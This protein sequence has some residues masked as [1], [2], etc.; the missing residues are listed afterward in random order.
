MCKEETY[1]LWVIT[2]LSIIAFRNQTALLA[3]YSFLDIFR[4]S[5]RAPESV[6]VSLILKGLNPPESVNSRNL[7]L[8]MK[9]DGLQISCIYSLP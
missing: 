2:T 4:T 5:S 9:E 6:S 8:Q 7:N 3:A 1:W